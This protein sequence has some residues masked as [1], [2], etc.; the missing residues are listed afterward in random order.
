MK[1]EEGLDNEEKIFYIET[2]RKVAEVEGMEV[3]LK[4]LNF[5]IVFI[6]RNEQP[7][8]SVSCRHLYLQKSS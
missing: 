2:L 5:S 6:E 7:N 4:N 1:C 3:S 8:I